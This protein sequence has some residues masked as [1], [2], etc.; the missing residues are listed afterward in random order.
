MDEQRVVRGHP[1]LARR[2]ELP[3]SHLAREG[4]DTLVHSLR[5]RHQLFARWGDRV[6]CAMALE[7]DGPERTL[8]LSKAAKHRRVIHPKLR[9]GCREAARIGDGLDQAEVVPSEIFEMLYH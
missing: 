1:Q 6:A 5:Q 9:C 3:P 4:G 8:D 7:Q 2:R